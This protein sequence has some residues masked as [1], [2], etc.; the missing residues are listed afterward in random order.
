[1]LVK[2][3][4]FYKPEHV[5]MQVKRKINEIRSKGERIDYITFVPNGEPTLDVNIGKEISLLKLLGFPIAVITNASLLWQSDVRKD[6]MIA[7]FVSLK[8]DAISQDLWRR[9]NRPHKDLKLDIIFDGIKKFSETFRGI[10]VSET[11]LID[12]INYESEL[13]EMAN[14]LGS[15]S[16]IDKA[17]IT[18]PTRP[19]T[20]R[21]VKPAKEEIINAA[22]KKFSEKL[23]S[24]V[25][26]LIGY[27]ED[28]FV[29][30]SDAEEDLLSITTVH[31]MRK[32]A[33]VEFL[34]KANAD[35]KLIEKL[36][37]ES[38]LIELEY[39]GKKYYMRKPE[40]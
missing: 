9:I 17:Y 4:A 21:W 29:S 35:W 16:K 14:F 22:F 13:A 33:V 6:L 28:T 20:E 7:D 32:E 12:D 40:S 36:L 18:V 38:K 39:E 1:M 26:Y 31:P 8:V 10:L 27:E 24:K 37:K 30:I 5:L 2:R 34:K 25:E 11:M 15:L 3:Q 23:G 19:P